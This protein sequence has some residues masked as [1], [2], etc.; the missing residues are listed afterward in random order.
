MIQ[1]QKQTIIKIYTDW[2]NHYLKKRY[3]ELNILSPTI[4]S[5]SP[6]PS[7]SSISSTSTSTRL[8]FANDYRSN[9]LDC[10][11]PALV[12]RS[13]TNNSNNNNNTN[14]NNNNNRRSFNCQRLPQLITSLA[15]DLRDGVLLIFLIESINYVRIASH[16]SLQHC[17]SFIIK[18]RWFEAYEESD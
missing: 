3:L 7:C 18:P 5:P 16:R 13:N 17:K 15:D 2:A 8:T 6:S 11:I 4:P 14:N 10:R 12:E 1:K 9:V